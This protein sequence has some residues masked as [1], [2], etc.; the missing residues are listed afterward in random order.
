MH[1]RRRLILLMAA[2][3]I[4][5]LLF[6]YPWFGCTVE[7]SEVRVVLNKR[8][9][10]PTLDGAAAGLTFNVTNYASCELHLESVTVTVHA[11]TYRDGSVDQLEFT[12]KQQ[13]SSTISPGH[14]LEVDYTFDYVFPSTPVRLSIWVEMSF[15]ESG[16]M[17]VY[18]GEVEIL[19][20]G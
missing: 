4:I 11:V 5:L 7:R 18:D 9:A 8:W 2:G 17:V 16:P 12:E 13:K 1:V 19:S 14:L 20:R 6:L 15:R 3:A 10:V